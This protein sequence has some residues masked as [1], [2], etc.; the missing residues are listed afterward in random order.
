[1]A[2]PGISAGEGVRESFPNSCLTVKIFH[3]LT[4]SIQFPVL[5][6][7]QQVLIKCLARCWTKVIWFH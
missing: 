4:P 1:M 6:G 5:P 2:K 7:I 3:L